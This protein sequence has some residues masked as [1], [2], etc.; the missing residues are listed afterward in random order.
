MANTVLN[1]PPRSKKAKKIKNFC[2]P[3]NNR[4]TEAISYNGVLR[5]PQ[6]ESLNVTRIAD[7]YTKRRSAFQKVFFGYVVE[8]EADAGSAPAEGAFSKASS[9]GSSPFAR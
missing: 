1:I 9:W 3:E 5:E 7:R 8:V 2:F 4:K 6:H